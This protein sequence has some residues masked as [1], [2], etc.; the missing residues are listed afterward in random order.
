MRWVDPWAA[1]PGQVSVMDASNV[2]SGG[3]WS[4]VDHVHTY[5]YICV[6]VCV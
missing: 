3:A 4:A 1:L 2:T 6:R 5:I